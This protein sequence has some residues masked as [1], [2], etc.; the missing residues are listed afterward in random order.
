MNKDDYVEL[1]EDRL[2]PTFKAEADLLTKIDGWLRFN[3]EDIRVKRVN[4]REVNYL[5][6]LS[7]TPWARLVINTAAQGLKCEGIYSASHPDEDIQR[8]WL[9]WDRNQMDRKQNALYRASFGYGLSYAM[10]LP[11]VDA[12]GEPGARI[13]THSPR[14][15]I[16]LYDDVVED[17]YPSI[18][19]R[20]IKQGRDTYHYRIIDEQYVHFLSRESNSEKARYLDAIEHGVGVVPVI[21]YA[22]EMDLEGRTPGEVQ[23]LIPLFGRINKT[24]YDRMLTQHFNSWKVRTATGLRE[25]DDNEDDDEDTQKLKMKL[26]QEDIL[27]GTGDTK[28]GTLDET[29]LKPF[30]EARDAD[31]EALA[32]SSQTPMTT[33]G[34]LVNVSAEGLIEARASLRAKQSDRK[35][36]WGDD[37]VQLIRLCAHIEKRPDDAK[38]FSIRAKWADDDATLLAAAVDALGKAATML[39]V[40]FELLWDRIPGV[41]ATTAAAWR[42]YAEENP[43]PEVVQAAAV[44]DALA[45]NLSVDMAAG[46]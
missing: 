46:A 6:D 9:P 44:R 37:H 25:T 13:T 15:F 42:A 5:K 27:V 11:G 30:I 1:L 4:D 45:A 36:V 7:K 19:L 20:V 39:N 17:E 12:F 32:A 21:R 18:A 14:E 38:D 26:R 43:N 28:F 35:T 10:A 3:P 24:D 8:M 16:A 2:L 41:D 31:L 33:F 34:K 29:N 40:P 23:P 22:N